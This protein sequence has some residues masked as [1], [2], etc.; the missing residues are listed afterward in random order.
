MTARLRSN[1]LTAFSK[2]LETLYSDV[3]ET[4]LCDRVLAC[5]H[6]L[7]QCDFASYSSVDLREARLHAF[8]V[9]PTTVHWPGMAVYQRHLRAD[10]CASH[11]MR[12]RRPDVLKISDFVGLR[13][14]RSSSV[15]AEVFRPS[16]CD[17]RMGFASQH[18]G[19]ISIASTLNRRRLDF[20]EEE[21]AL[22]DLLR[23]H[24]L[25][26][27]HQA[28]AHG[29]VRRERER[30]RE[31]LGEVFNAGLVE[32]DGT[33]R[34]HWLTRYA[35]SLLADFFPGTSRHFSANLPAELERR[36]APSLRPRPTSRTNGPRPVQPSVWHVDGPE[37]RRLAIRLAASAAGRW[38]VLLEET[39][40]AAVIHLLVS[41]LQLTRREA[42]ILYWLTQGKTNWEVATILGI[43]GKTVG[44]HLEHIFA[45]LGVENRTSAVRMAGEAVAAG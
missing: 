24:L 7:F 39:N 15:F 35:E 37:Q 23:P 6:G 25:Q 20:T 36:L 26:A 43:T 27:N 33:G 12:T 11:I 5:L 9:S 44:K 40:A 45:K 19:P 34:I 2:A 8:T 17:R 32:I 42:E 29:L 14:Y 22:L 4:T 30:E 21:R 28:H 31:S 41:A 38:Q 1:D 10:P 18:H 3:S 16:G 13:V